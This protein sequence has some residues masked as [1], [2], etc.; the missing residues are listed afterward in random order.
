MR[1]AVTSVGAVLDD[2]EHGLRVP[3]SAAGL[4]TTLP[5]MCFAGVGALTPKLPAGS[6]YTACSSSRSSS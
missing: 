6:A 1:T 3:S 5:V 2:I 4:M